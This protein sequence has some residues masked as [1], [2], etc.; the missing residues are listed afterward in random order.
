MKLAQEIYAAIKQ[1]GLEYYSPREL[2][3]ICDQ[4]REAEGD[5]AW[6]ILLAKIDG[7][8]DGDDLST[9]NDIVS[10]CGN[11]ALA[12]YFAYRE[13]WWVFDTKTTCDM[14]MEAPGNRAMMIYWAKRDGWWFYSKEKAR[15]AIL[16]API[17]T[18]YNRDVYA[19]QVMMLTEGVA[20]PLTVYHFGCRRCSNAIFGTKHSE[21][22]C[23][24][25]LADMDHIDI[26]KFKHV[27]RCG[28]IYK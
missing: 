25:C 13:K 26:E 9:C 23:P 22:K 27:I 1:N 6:T 4:I 28:D 15:D 16:E 7:W 5:R 8:W 20:V 11:R 14:I 21:L 12:L 19:K 3:V 17:D 24:T 2:R 10:A 18:E